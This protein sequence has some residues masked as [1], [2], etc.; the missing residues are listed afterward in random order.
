MVENAE[1]SLNAEITEITEKR[2]LLLCDIRD[3]YVD[4]VSVIS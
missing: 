3:L 1:N 2:I 4:P